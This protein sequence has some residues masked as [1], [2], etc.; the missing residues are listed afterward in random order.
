MIEKILQLQHYTKPRW[1][2]IKIP[3]KTQ[4]GQ[5][6][7]KQ[8]KLLKKSKNKSL[9]ILDFNLN[10][11]E[12]FQKKSNKIKSKKIKKKILN[13]KR[14]QLIFLRMGTNRIMNWK[15]RKKKNNKKTIKKESKFMSMI[16]ISMR[17]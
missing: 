13:N 15:S 10:W 2:T 6:S 12:M 16:M 11:M 8:K 4:Q 17:K 5:P 9:K 1:K 14:N 3:F 7:N